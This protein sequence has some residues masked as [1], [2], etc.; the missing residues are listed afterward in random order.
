MIRGG[1]NASAT[2]NARLRFDLSVAKFAE[3]AV[4]M[5]LPSVGLGSTGDT[6]GVVTVPTVPTNLA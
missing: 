4:A 1:T 6:A 3:L 2:P 5:T